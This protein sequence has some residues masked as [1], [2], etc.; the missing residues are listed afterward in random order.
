MIPA[1]LNVVDVE[2]TNIFPIARFLRISTVGPTSRA[3]IK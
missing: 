3:K 2:L 1:T